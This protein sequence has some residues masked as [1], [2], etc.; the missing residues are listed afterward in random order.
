MKEKPYE[1][2]GKAFNRILNQIILEVFLLK[3]L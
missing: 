2:Y 3:S 1:F